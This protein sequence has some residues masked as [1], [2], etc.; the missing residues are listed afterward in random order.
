MFIVRFV[1]GELAAWS[2]LTIV[3]VGIDPGFDWIIFL[4]E[5]DRGTRNV[6]RTGPEIVLQGAS[7]K[8]A[9]HADVSAEKWMLESTRTQ[10]VWQSSM[11]PLLLCACT[12][13]IRMPSLSCWVTI[14][15]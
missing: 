11:V 4:S 2:G 3:S 13:S 15:L 9:L 10:L 7:V 12:C 8:Q 5:Y 6:A 14:I 1:Y